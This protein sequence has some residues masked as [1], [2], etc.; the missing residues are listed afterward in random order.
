[1]SEEYDELKTLAELMRG[2][3]QSLHL[4]AREDQE[5]MLAEIEFT[6]RMF[7]GDDGDAICAKPIIDS[8]RMFVTNYVYDTSCTNV[9]GRI[10]KELQEQMKKTL[11][12][13]TE[14]GCLR[15]TGMGTY[16]RHAAMY[17]EWSKGFAARVRERVRQDEALAAVRGTGL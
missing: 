2:P 13:L 6:A 12:I 9:I 14:S 17:D 16:E 8:I 10:T 3:S 15:T 4:T 11:D 5:R 7:E 1:M